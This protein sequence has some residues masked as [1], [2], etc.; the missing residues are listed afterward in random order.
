[1]ICNGC[2]E[3]IKDKY[4]VFQQKAF[5]TGC[6]LCFSCKKPILDDVI[7]TFKNMFFMHVDCAKTQIEE[8]NEKGKIISK[9]GVSTHAHA[10]EAQNLKDTDPLKI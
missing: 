10:N 1:M 3:F 9:K 8:L 5:H 6:I 4:I 2:M 7:S